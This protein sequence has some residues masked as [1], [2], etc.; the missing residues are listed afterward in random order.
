MGLD[1]MLAGAS[2]PDA[3]APD[4]PALRAAAAELSE[5]RVGLLDDERQFDELGAHSPEAVRKMAIGEVT[6]GID[7]FEQ[8]LATAATWPT[9]VQLRDGSTVLLDGGVT[10]GEDASPTWYGTEAMT[11]T[12]LLG[13]P[14]T[15]YGSDPPPAPIP[16]T[17]QIWADEL[18]GI[19]RSRLAVVELPLGPDWQLGRAAVPERDIAILE[20]LQQV[21]AGSYSRTS[22]VLR[23]GDAQLFIGDR[24]LPQSAAAVIDGWNVLNVFEALGGRLLDDIRE[25]RWRAEIHG[26]SQ[27]KD[28]GPR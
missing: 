26:A 23:I 20:R 2:W 7:E 21:L 12:G 6:E 5:E 22:A 13:T 14:V 10:S 17:V 3:L 27:G 9:I 28:E 8:A 16:R 1:F 24:A 19:R 4:W 15:P 18:P 25:A 11:L